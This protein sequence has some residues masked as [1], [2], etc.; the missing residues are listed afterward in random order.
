MQSRSSSYINGLDWV[1]AFMSVAVVTWHLRSFGKPLL[2]TGK[3]AVGFNLGE[4]L[5]FHVVPVSSRS[6][7]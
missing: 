3:F 4:L 7:C 6:S 5:Y 1:R 2:Y